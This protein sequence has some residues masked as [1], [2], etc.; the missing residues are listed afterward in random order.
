[1]SKQK[2][3]RLA[4]ALEAFWPHD[5][6]RAT[7]EAAAALLRRWP[8]GEIA[9]YQYLFDGYYGPVWRNDSGPWNGMQPKDIRP[10]YTAPPDQSERIAALE[11]ALEQARVAMEALR[12]VD[13]H[14]ALTEEDADAINAKLDAALI[15]IEEVRK[16]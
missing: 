9:A 7:R 10:L 1:M 3:Q 12:S 4:D 8:D 2:A 11:A 15:K 16:C 13:V 14:S 5:E 6:G